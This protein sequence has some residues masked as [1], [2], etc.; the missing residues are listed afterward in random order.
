MSKAWPMSSKIL[1]LAYLF[2]SAANI[3]G[4][5]WTKPFLMPL[6]IGWAFSFLSFHKTFNDKRQSIAF[7]PW[8]FLA[9]IF[10]WFGDLALMGSAEMWFLLG[11]VS[12]GA[13][14][15]SY[16]VMFSK[17]PGPGL[18]SA[19]KFLLFPYVIYWVFL[20]SIISAGD[21][22]VPVGLYSAFLIVMAIAAL[23]AALRLVKPWR[24][25]PAYGAL[26]FTV[27]DSLLALEEFNGIPIPSSLI[28][29][30]YLAGQAMLVAGIVLGQAPTDSLSRR[31]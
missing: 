6:L 20:N 21:L 11:L 2:A 26:L 3:L 28:M 19:W 16:I 8:L 15:L 17:L 10:S 29:L 12:F 9:L 27:S 23:N 25:V 13:A 24:F 5:W 22:R 30:T 1:A 7:L 31:R 14:Q 4:V 18:V